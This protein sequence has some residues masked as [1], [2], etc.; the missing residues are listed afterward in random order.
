MKLPVRTAL[1]L[2]ALILLGA[3]GAGPTVS[4]SAKA[5]PP[6]APVNGPAADYP[7]VIGEPF[8]V[9]GTTYTPADRLNSDE[10]GYAAVG[11]DGGTGVSAAHKTLPLPSY[12]EVTALASGRTILARVERRGPMRNDAVI[13]LSPGAAEQL[14][15]TG[16]APTAVRVRRVNPPEQERA[17]LRA[18]NRAPERMETPRGLLTVL[19]RKLD[20]REPLS[21]P[22]TPATAPAVAPPV[23]AKA[24][25]KPAPAPKPAPKPVP[26]VA[27]APAAKPATPSKP[28]AAPA[29]AAV[30]PV[31]KSAATGNLVVQ[32]GAFSTAERAR[33]VAGKLDGRVSKPGKFWLARLGP[34]A[35]RAEAE[36]ALAKARAAGYSDARIQRAD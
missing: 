5:P 26:P 10:V 14:G 15:V 20:A 29:S 9:D 3:A 17:Q 19:M 13:E 23:A 8:T 1:P 32:V 36:A 21:N 22:A 16:D 31:P 35:S 12:V 30:A 34:F 25:P 11:V 2:A 4:A 28:P 33:G 18:G 6:P 27:A 24:T 7:V